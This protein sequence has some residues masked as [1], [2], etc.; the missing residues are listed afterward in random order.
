MWNFSHARLTAYLAY[1]IL[2]SDWSDFATY[3]FELMK[4]TITTG[5]SVRFDHSSPETNCASLLNL[6]PGEVE[7]H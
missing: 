6:E 4:G 3:P 7:A 5:H 2:M 1:S